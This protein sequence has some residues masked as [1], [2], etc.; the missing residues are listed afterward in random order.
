M[1]LLL[2]QLSGCTVHI[3]LILHILRGQESM[4]ETNMALKPMNKIVSYFADR[5]MWKQFT[6]AGCCRRF[7]LAFWRRITKRKHVSEED[8]STKLKRC[9][10]TK[11]LIFIGVGK[12]VGV[13]IYVLIGVATQFAGKS[14][15]RAKR[16]WLSRNKSQAKPTYLLSRTTLSLRTLDSHWQSRINRHPLWT[17]KSAQADLSLGRTHTHE[18]TFF[19]LCATRMFG[20]FI[21]RHFCM[22]ILFLVESNISVDAFRSEA[23]Q[24]SLWLFQD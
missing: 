11:R 10:S 4:F 16:K 22:L 23:L 9:L 3:I 14:A 21:I 6:M 20:T 1:L 24:D 18:N 17:A 2:L 5:I 8:T 19:F 15:S 12:T 13:G 7:S